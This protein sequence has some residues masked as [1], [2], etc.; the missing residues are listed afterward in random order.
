MWLVVRYYCAHSSDDDVLTP[1]RDVLRVCVRGLDPAVLHNTRC[2][3]RNDSV[4][5][6]V[7]FS[8]NGDFSRKWGLAEKFAEKGVHWVH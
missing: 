3:A 2:R 6:G 1:K 7:N 8:R 5:F 4:G